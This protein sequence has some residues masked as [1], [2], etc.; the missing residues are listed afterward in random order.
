VRLAKCLLN[1]AVGAERRVS[2]RSSLEA[3]GK[4]KSEPQ[5]QR[6]EDSSAVALLVAQEAENGAERTRRA[7]G[8]FVGG[9]FVD[10]SAMAGRAWACSRSDPMSPG[11]RGNRWVG[12]TLLAIAAFVAS[13]CVV[14][15]VHVTRVVP[16]QPVTAVWTVLDEGVA[17]SAAAPP[18][19]FEGGPSPLTMALAPSAAVPPNPFEGGPSPLTMAL[20]ATV[21]GG[22]FSVRVIDGRAGSEAD[23]EADA[24]AGDNAEARVRCEGCAAIEYDAPEA[25]GN[26]AEVAS[27]GSTAALAGAIAVDL[28][29]QRPGAIHAGWGVANVAC[30]A[31][32]LRLRQAG[33]RP[34]AA[35]DLENHCASAVDVDL[36][37]VVHEVRA[38]D[39][40][41]LRT[42]PRGRS[43][44]ERVRLR[45]GA[46][47]SR[48]VRLDTSPAPVRG[49]CLDLGRAIGAERAMLCTTPEEWA[50][51]LQDGSP[52]ILRP[53]P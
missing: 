28:G 2:H 41:V 20:E 42:R 32:R 21:G 11:M 18:S 6:A 31:A 3:G 46:H 9:P 53:E 50:K 51:A 37:R 52:L 29:A 1:E 45:P 33:A 36:G 49:F 23:D 13:G 35:L 27:G 34:L 39:G 8:R 22:A 47:V 44:S 40:L 48:T 25:E 19:P 15:S 30:L 12:S 4:Q 26:A 14:R 38:A 43:T 16:T 5:P 10:G 24:A 17:P 7:H